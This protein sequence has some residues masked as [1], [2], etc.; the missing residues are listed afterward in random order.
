MGTREEWVSTRLSILVFRTNKK[1][2]HFFLESLGSEMRF[3]NPPHHHIT[4]WDRARLIHRFRFPENDKW[5]KRQGR[6]RINK[7]QRIRIRPTLFRAWRRENQKERPQRI[8][9]TSRIY[10]T[11]KGETGQLVLCHGGRKSLLILLHCHYQLKPWRHFQFHYTTTLPL[12]VSFS[13]CLPFQ[14]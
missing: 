2:S 7:R 9:S 6:E 13:L 5:E 11:L 14:S 4:S 10:L 3:L 8:F 12:S 1:S